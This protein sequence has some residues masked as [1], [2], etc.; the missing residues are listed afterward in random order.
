MTESKDNPKIDEWSNEREE[1]YQIM[2]ST[3]R[4]GVPELLQYLTNET[5][6]FIAPSSTK[7][8]DAREGGLLHH[9]LKVYYNLIELSKIYVNDIPDDGSSLAIIALLHDL[10]K[11]N[12]YKLTKK[13]LPRKDADGNLIYNEFGG[14]IW[15]TTMAYEFDDHLP[16]GHGEKSVI[17]LQRYIRLTDTEI[18]AIRWHMMAYDDSRNSYAGNL[19]ITTAS[20]K[21]RIIPLMHSAD[22]LASFLE[23][24]QQ[25]GGNK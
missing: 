2:K 16:L 13:Q 3:G 25:T 22:L 9:S 24:K 6:F 8:H 12:I 4:E 21:F 5:D 10:C 20:D 18:F 1:F 19:A 11:V 7:Y 23:L 17:M 15:D 14:K